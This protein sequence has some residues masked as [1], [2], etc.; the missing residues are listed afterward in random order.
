MSHSSYIG[1]LVFGAPMLLILPFSFVYAFFDYFV[2][3]GFARKAASGMY[4]LS[5]A[6]LWVELLLEEI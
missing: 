5:L 3:E 4:F 2:N 1:F 6:A